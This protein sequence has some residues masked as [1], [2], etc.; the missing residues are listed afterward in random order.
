M[1]SA[2]I[3]SHIHVLGRETKPVPVVV[4]QMFD[5]SDTSPTGSMVKPGMYPNPTLLPDRFFF[6]FTPIITIRHPAR[7]IASFL[8]AY[9]HYGDDHSH[10][11]FVV[12]D[13]S[14]R[15]E[16]LMFDLLKRFGRVPIVID[17]DKLVADPQGQ[18]KKVCERLG[19]DESQIQYTW[20]PPGELEHTT[21]GEAFLGNFN[22]SIGV[23]PDPITAKPVEMKEEVE[24]WAK[25]W[26]EETARILE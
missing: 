19:I 21:A 11:D 13:E 3:H 12:Y 5:V 20:D 17:G 10:P 22:R 8:Q 25:D 16:R 6:S 26:N 9:N 15:L 2:K 18:M 23:V 1:S 7:V 14:F 24:R 4:D